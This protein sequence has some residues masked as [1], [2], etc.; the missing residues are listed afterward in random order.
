[1][2]YDQRQETVLDRL[3]RARVTLNADEY[4]FSQSSVRFLGQIVDADGIRPDPHRA[5]CSPRSATIRWEP[6]ANGVCLQNPHSN[7]AELCLD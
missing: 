3:A 7:R 2:Q 1:M 4:V 5:G 6:Q